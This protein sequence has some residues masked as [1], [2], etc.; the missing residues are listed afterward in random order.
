VAFTKESSLKPA[1]YS[2]I[3]GLCQVGFELAKALI[4]KIKIQKKAAV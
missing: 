1:I 3:S 2:V 4:Y